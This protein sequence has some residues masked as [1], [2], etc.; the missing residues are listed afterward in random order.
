MTEEKEA[1]YIQKIKLLEEKITS[2][3][4]LFDIQ[5]LDI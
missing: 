4:E 3:K 5:K 2:Y 1:Y